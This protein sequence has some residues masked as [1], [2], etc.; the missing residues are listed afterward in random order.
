V[1][2]ADGEGLPEAG[3]R[4]GMTTHAVRVAM[5]V[6]GVVMIVVVIVFMIVR[7]GGHRTA[8]FGQSTRTCPRGSEVTHG[9]PRF[10]T[11]NPRGCDA[12]DFFR[13]PIIR[14]QRRRN[15]NA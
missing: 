5:I 9:G 11:G 6:A 15:D 10:N 1:R 12:L 4:V 13:H 8:S 2:H 7:M 14:R 3:G